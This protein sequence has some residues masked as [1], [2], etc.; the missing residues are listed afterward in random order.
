MRSAHTYGRTDPMIVVVVVWWEK[1]TRQIGFLRIIDRCV[2][3]SWTLKNKL[4]QSI[5]VLLRFIFLNEIYLILIIRDYILSRYAIRECVFMFYNKINSR[6]I[7]NWIFLY[8]WDFYNNKKERKI[9]ISD[10][11]NKSSLI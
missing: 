8:L 7:K 3:S 4:G 9:Q 2:D 6:C 10:A 5:F 11:I 1:S